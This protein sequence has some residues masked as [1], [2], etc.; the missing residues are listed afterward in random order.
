MTYRQTSSETNKKENYNTKSSSTTRKELP[1]ILFNKEYE[2]C[3]YMVGH[4][5]CE[6]REEDW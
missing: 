5:D 3:P 2:Y 1:M 4:I 6:P